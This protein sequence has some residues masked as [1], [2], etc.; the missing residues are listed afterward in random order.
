MRDDGNGSAAIVQHHP[1]GDVP[2]EDARLDDAIRKADEL[3]LSSLKSEE[4]RRSRRRRTVTFTI[5]GGLIMFTAACVILAVLAQTTAAPGAGASTGESAEQSATE[6]WALW[7]QRKLPEAEAKFEQAVKADP[8]HANAWN[9]LGWARLNQ[10]KRHEAEKAFQEVVTLEPDH[11]AAL[12]GLGW[13]YY[14]YRGYDSAEKFFLRAAANNAS[15][16]WAGLAQ[17]YLLQGKYDQA[18]PWAILVSKEPGADAA[19]SA[20]MIEAARAKKLDPALRK[21]IEP[22]VEKKS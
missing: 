22:E 8:K 16:S 11:P 15:A 20:Q 17:L 1:A 19:T 12:N 5:V 6:G 2:T 21:Q 13:I 4:H 14:G 18:L 10:G 7:Q 3:L 9:G